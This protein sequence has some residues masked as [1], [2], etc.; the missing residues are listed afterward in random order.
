MADNLTIERFSMGTVHDWKMWLEDYCIYGQLKKWNSEKLVTNLRFF[1]SGDIKNCI[2]QTCT[3]SPTTT[4]EDISAAVVKLLGGTPDPLIAIRQLESVS[5]NGNVGQTL[6]SIGDLIPLAYPTITERAHRDQIIWIHLQKLIPAEY[7]RDLIKAG[8]DQLDAAVDR[9]RAFERADATIRLPPAGLYRTQSSTEAAGQPAPPEPTGPQMTCYVC[10]LPDHVCN[11][12]PFRQDICGQCERR[13]HLSTVCRLRS[14]QPR[15][16]GPVQER[17]WGNGR[18]SVPR[19]PRQTVFRGSA[20]APLTWNGEDQTPTP[21]PLLQQDPLQKQPAQWIPPLQQPTPESQQRPAPRQ[22]Q[23]WMPPPPPPEP[24][25][26]PE[27][28]PTL[29]EPPRQQ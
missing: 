17:S 7:Q 26:R 3:E 20:V 29:Q 27:R 22:Q 13:G 21:M 19:G 15:G 24:Q 2:R 12:C 14:R 8:V 6:L 16:R 5:Y 18:Q 9:I 4:L 10:G 28:Q 25:Q 11:A 1:V 23:P